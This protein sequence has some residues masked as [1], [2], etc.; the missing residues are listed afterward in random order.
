M[1]IPSYY[2]RL[3]DT[4]HGFISKAHP[5][6]IDWLWMDFNCLIYHCLRKPTM[7]PYVPGN[8]WEKEFIRQIGVYLIHVVNEVKPQRGVYIAIDGVVPMAKMRQQRLRRFKS[9]WMSTHS[10]TYGWDTNAITPGTRF[11]S[12]LKTGL[13]QLCERRT[14]GSI[15]YIL[16]SS[17][18]PGEGEHKIMEQWR[19]GSYEGSYAIYGLD[20]DLIVLSLLNSGDHPCWLFREETEAGYDAVGDE[21]Y[22]W[23]SIDVLRQYIQGQIGNR[24]TIADYAF[25][26][27]FLGNDFLPQ[28]L[29]FKMRDGGHD[30]LLE[31]LSRLDRRGERLI[32]SDGSVSWN[33]VEALLQWLASNEES[34][35]DRFIRRKIGLGKMTPSARVGEDAWPLTEQVERILWNRSDGKEGLVE[36]WKDIYR[37]RWLEGGRTDLCATYLYGMEWIWS[38]YIG[39]SDKICYN[40]MY[41]LHMPPLWSDILGHLRTKR[42]DIAKQFPG[43]IQ[44]RREDI[45]PVEQLC[46]VLPV[47]SWHLL[48]HASREKKLIV[49]APWL[50]PRSFGFT[51][52]GKRY[53]WE[54]EADIPVPT[55]RQVKMLLGE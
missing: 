54:C 22:S 47:D 50:F 8:E 25:A 6:S 15:R 44:V 9:A 12:A 33:G 4:V 38:Y 1:G 13:A 29:S 42:E 51:S 24:M 36:G 26:M 20:A 32:A 35:I 16:S 11:M 30:A 28:S 43:M 31:C 46:L 45:R 49:R 52:V 14:T 21:F 2:K 5:G 17:D 27:S 55:I 53:F 37:Q 3:A 39:N 23:L 40:W 48:E 10:D 41:P 19:T 18:E 7:P 34:R